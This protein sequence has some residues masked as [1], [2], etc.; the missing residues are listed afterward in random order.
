[1]SICSICGLS[2]CESGGNHSRCEP[3][4]ENPSLA[5]EAKNIMDEVKYIQKKYGLDLNQSLEVVKI[6]SIRSNLESIDY[7]I[8][9]INEI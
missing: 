6:Y 2:F 3:C 8:S 1:M 5:K 4:R 7:D 9:H